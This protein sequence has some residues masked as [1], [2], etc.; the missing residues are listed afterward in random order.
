V[1]VT[2][3]AQACLTVEQPGGGRVLIDPGTLVRDG[4]TLDDLLPVDAVLYTHEHADHLDRDWAEQLRDRGV[5]IHANAAVGALL[6]LEAEH[7]VR[8]GQRFTA[9]GFS[10]EAFDL[11]HMPMVDGSPGPPNLGFLLDD[12]LLHPGDGIDLAG[13]YAE[14]L[15]VPIAGPSLSA[16]GA[17]VMVEDTRASYAVPI[18]YDVFPGDPERFARSC[19]L[20]EVRVLG[21]GES[22]TF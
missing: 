12:R 17:Y 15:A 10:V 13:L 18:H 11:P 8:G 14:V 16:R 21:V 9:G 22:T 2:K 19:D 7:I 5:P 6:G 20:A 3:Y 1:K 4:A